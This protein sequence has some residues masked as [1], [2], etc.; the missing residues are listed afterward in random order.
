M[1]M[2][3]RPPRLYRYRSLGKDYESLD[4]EL[5]A[6]TDGYVHCAA[7][8][9]LNDPMEGVFTSSKRLRNSRK[10]QAIRDEIIS[11]KAQLGIC[12]F[13]EVHDNPLM[14]AHYA[15]EFKGVCVAYNL[16]RLFRNLART[17]RGIEINFVRMYY[18]E[19]DPTVS[20][21]AKETQREMA[22]IVLSYKNY[23]WLHEREWRMF[24]NQG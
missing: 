20:S 9:D 22:K 11:N 6:V 19:V 7:F 21:R 24:A 5:E 18:N 10:Y 14:W 16:G 23:R 8:N 2:S 15:D 12:S 17:A 13:S 1:V 3:V 4:R